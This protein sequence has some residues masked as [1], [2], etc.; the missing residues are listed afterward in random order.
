M[1]KTKGIYVHIV[2]E[3]KIALKV[4]AKSKDITVSLL[5]RLALNKLLD[6]LKLPRLK[7]LRIYRRPSTKRYQ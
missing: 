1:T 5:T 3:D 6:S 4:I 7:S 2:N